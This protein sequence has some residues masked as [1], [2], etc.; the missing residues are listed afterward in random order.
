MAEMKKIKGLSILALFLVFLLIST[1]CSGTEK[2]IS[3]SD[4]SGTTEVSKE[5][6]LT[7][8]DESEKGE[9][10]NSQEKVRLIGLKGP[11]SIAMAKLS[12]SDKYDFQI[13]GAPDEAV[14]KIVKGEADIAAL[15]S[16]LAVLLYARSEGEIAVLNIKTL[17]VLH[18][19]AFRDDI[20]TLSDLKGQKIISAG[21]GASSE[22]ILK[23][24]IRE[25]GLEETDITVDWK[26]EHSEVISELAKDKNLIAMLPEPFVN[27]AEAK[28]DNIKR[29]IDL[30]KLWDEYAKEKGDKSAQVMGVCV[31][32]KDFINKH[33]EM[34]KEFLKD[35]ENSVNFVNSNEEEAGKL[36]AKLSIVPENIASKVIKGSN[37]VFISGEEC[38][39]KLSAFLQVLEKEDPKSVGGKLPCDDFYY[40]PAE[41]AF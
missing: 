13:L 1:S 33:P 10:K 3:N 25:S 26:K 4:D 20:K 12:E 30:N 6:E 35:A 9:I 27:L 21:K 7:S 31:A 14:S 16:N 5:S 36:I 15:P 24:L 40:M 17:G 29:L 19:V 37:T 2:K 22:Y 28:F 38:K 34:V 32:R 8:S 39:E 18:I 11:T 41:D 23:H